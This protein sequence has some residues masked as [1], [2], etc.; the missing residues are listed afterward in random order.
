MFF[1]ARLQSIHHT[2]G[3]LVDWLFHCRE[4]VASKP[5]AK[6]PKALGE[7]TASLEGSAEETE[8]LHGYLKEQLAAQSALRVHSR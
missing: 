1:T 2:N 5:N 8:R 7:K 6:P 4:K 3:W